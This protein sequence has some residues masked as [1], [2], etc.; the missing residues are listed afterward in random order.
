MG[1]VSGPEISLLGGFPHRRSGV[2]L[3]L[4]PGFFPPEFLSPVLLSR[5]AALRLPRPPCAP[6]RRPRGAPGRGP[7]WC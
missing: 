2:G 5:P 6:P 1:S 3:P 7:T 4:A